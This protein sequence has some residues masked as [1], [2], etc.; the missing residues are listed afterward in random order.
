MAIDYNNHVIETT[1][2]TKLNS[3][4]PTSS[5]NLLY[6]SGGDL[7]WGGTGFGGSV[8]VSDTGESGTSAV[9]N[10]VVLSVSSYNSLGTKDPNTL[11]FLY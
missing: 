10:V 6:N 9:K 7:I 11:Y 8:I 2:G 3:V 1:G 5:T 4:I